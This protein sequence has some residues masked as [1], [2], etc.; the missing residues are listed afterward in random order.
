MV[1]FQEVECLYHLTS[2]AL[3]H[4]KK[5]VCCLCDKSRTPLQWC[6]AGH[7]NSDSICLYSGPC[8]IMDY[9][10]GLLGLLSGCSARE[11][12]MEVEGKP[13]SSSC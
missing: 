4:E 10:A 2:A 3:L 8:R 11:E 12:T 5:K 7:L 13:Q 6:L 9:A 1:D